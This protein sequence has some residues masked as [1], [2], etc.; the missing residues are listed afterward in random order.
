MSRVLRSPSLLGLARLLAWG[1]GYCAAFVV[2]YDYAQLPDELPLSR[3][4]TAHKTMALALRVPLAHLAFIGLCELAARCLS[5][6]PAEQRPAAERV[7]ATL[8][9]T[10][11]VKA[12]LAAKEVINLPEADPTTT[13][14]SFLVMV[15][16][17]L[18]AAWFVRPL[19]G[20]HLWSS[21]RATRLEQALAALLVAL[22]AVL[23]LAPLALG[24]PR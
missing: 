12:W 14:A 9:C 22:I 11:G 20:S 18:L 7:G 1:A 10:A 8:L 4:S 2:A 5:R 6:A 24:W 23:N 16:G 3:W 19:L 13:L 15:T 17:C 21:L